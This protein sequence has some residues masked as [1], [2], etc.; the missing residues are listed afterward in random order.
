MPKLDRIILINSAGFDYLEFPVGGHGQVIGVNGHGKT[1][2]LRT[3]LFFYL[4]TNEKSPYALHETKSDFVSHYLGD[5]PSYLIYEVARGDGQPAYHIAVTRPAGRIQFHFVDA[6]FLKD[7]YLD[8]S[9]VQPIEAVEQRLQEA[10]CACD[11]VTSYEEFSRRLYGITSSPYAVFR[12][13][14]RSSGQVSILPRIISGIFTVSQLD[15]DK[16]KAALT[17]GVREDS[18][19]TELDLLLLKSQLENFRRV[20]RAVSTYLRYEDD[21]LRLVDVAEEFETAKGQ[22]QRAIEDLVRM[23]KRLPEKVRELQESQTSVEGDRSA[24]IAQYQ[25]EKAGLDQMIRQLGKHIA[26]LEGKIQKGEETQEDYLARQIERKAA[27]L[28]TLPKLGE[29]KRLAEGEYAALTAKYDNE[30]ERKEKMLAN[31]QQGWA[32]LSRQ[33]EQRKAEA[34]RALGHALEQLNGERTGVFSALED[35]QHRAKSSFASRRAGLEFARTNL[36]DEFRALAE[37]SEPQELKKATKDLEDKRRKQRE[38]ASRLQGLRGE[39]VLQREKRERAREKIDQKAE[40]ERSAWQAKVDQTKAQRDCAAEELE[41]FDESLARF[42]QI[43]SPE[44]WPGAAKALARETLF[45]NAQ[46]LEAKT[47]KKGT[48]S[49]WGVEFSTEKLPTPSVSYD[50]VALDAK[51]QELQKVLAHEHDQLTA[52][53]QR[54][55]AAV[56]EFE[57]QAM[58][59]HSTLQSKIDSSAELGRSLSNEI[60]HLENRIITLQSQFQA[61]QS[62]WRGRLA[63]RDAEL[64]EQEQRLRQDERES[65]NQFQCRRDRVEQDFKGRKKRLTKEREDRLLA[66][67]REENETAQQ[68]D[69]ERERIEKAFQQRL[70]QQGVKTPLIQAARRRAD[71]AVHDISRIGGYTNEVVEFQRMK[72][73]FVDPLDSLRFQWR[74]DKESLDSETA[75]LGKLEERHRQATE[76]L[77]GRQ[78]SLAE[79][80]RELQLDEGAVKRFRGD[81]RFLQEWG[82][83]DREDLTPAPFY[84]AGAARDFAQ[85]AEEGHE[86][87]AEVGRSGDK[88]ARAFLNHF[89]AETLDRKVLGLSPIHEHFDWYIFVGAELRL[90][91]NGRGIQGM[92]QIQTQEFEQLI[93]NICAKNADFREGIRQVKQTAALVQT[94]LERNNFVDVLDSIELKVE[95]I[96]NN[97]TQ[98]LTELEGFAGVTFSPDRDLFGKRADR[99]QIDKAI[100]TFA[101]LVREIENYRDKCLRL[102]DYF[103]FLIR[104]H[105]NGHDMGWRKSLDHIG[106]TGTDY[107]VKM[108]IYLSL[109]EVYRERAIDSKAGSTVHCV[110]DETGVLAPKY[111][112]SVLEYA[113]SRG[114]IL[115]TAGHSQQTV[116]FEN[117]VRVR[118]RGQRFGGQ[119]VLRKVLKCD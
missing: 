107:L 47:V 28:E 57:K 30:S 68:R 39:I 51:L 44:T 2:L 12:P 89:D 104:V 85:A 46:E 55:V 24:A 58:Q 91:V 13:A 7:Y 101:R 109:I 14:P 54:Y 105:E 111:V 60:D 88:S 65:E 10:R 37:T 20:N 38:E 98:I 118:K 22:R 25:T 86:Q 78:N 100:D 40:A 49:A 75:R 90:F 80:S 64:K 73:E 26:V 31:V 59:A 61:H 95:R 53:Q 113:K 32:E 63:N 94:N 83:F 116:G 45:H 81:K 21:A 18:L 34:E 69:A 108:L 110:L 67:G 115:I 9:F 117:W 119:T 1:T 62:E 52:T 36:N 29:Q 102:T 42:F 5:P 8:G 87:R 77:R 103:D 17:C 16:L 106:S 41:K 114:I 56:V 4:G 11:L 76:V 99:D 66:I 112:R 70:I 48:N 27:D 92:K 33:Y 15:A 43:E 82:F 19:A 23:A 74:N 84:R 97:L 93:R 35:E 79:H 72:R 6:P 96:D 50:R 3:I 71:A